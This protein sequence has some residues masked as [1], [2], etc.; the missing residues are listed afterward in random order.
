MVLGA[1]LV[2]GV[3]TLVLRIALDVVHAALDPR[4]RFAGGDDAG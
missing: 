1:L 2:V 4:I 3:I